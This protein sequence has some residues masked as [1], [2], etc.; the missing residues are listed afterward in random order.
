MEPEPFDE[1]RVTTES[2]SAVYW[3][4]IKPDAEDSSYADESFVFRGTALTE[5]LRWVEDRM[6]A[7]TQGVARVQLLIPG[8]DLLLQAA[9][10]DAEEWHGIELA[11]IPASG[12][13]SPRDSL[14]GR[15]R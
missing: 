13:A 15:R 5:V 9:G 14:S 1:R 3:V 8:G 11:V 6:G 4:A 12:S 2:R 10:E 7:A